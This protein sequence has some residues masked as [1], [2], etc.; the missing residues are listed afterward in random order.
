M[1]PTDRKSIIQ[2]IANEAAVWRRELHKHPQTMYEET[3]AASFISER[4]REWG[5]QHEC[6][7]AKTG[8][9]ATIEGQAAAGGRAIAFRADTDALDISEDS[10][11]PWKSIYPGKMHACGHDGHTATVLALARYLQQTRQFPGKVRLIFQPAEE[12][13]R[14]AARM[15]AEGLLEKYPFDEIYGFHNNPYSPAGEFSICPGFMLAATDFFELSLS[16]RGGHAAMPH[17]CDD[18]IVAGSQ[19]VSAVQSLVSRETDP[20][21]AAVISITNFHGGTGAANVMPE[22]VTLSGTVRTFKPETRVRIEERMAAL[23]GHVASMYRLQHR[24]AYNRITDAVFN[25]AANVVYSSDTVE[26]L[27]GKDALKPQQPIMGGEDFGS[28]LELRPGSFIFAGQGEA[29]RNSPHSQGLHT[30]RYEFNDA[31]IPKVVEYFADLAERR[32]LG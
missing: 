29:D 1:P 14:G 3:F 32:T 18:A 16:G 2:S 27:F 21:D 8:V 24:F 26:R 4:L 6:G 11:S 17:L 31:I 5:I 9:V 10:D 28:F 20:V 23:T 13:G 30:P 22:K 12:G 19:L 25:H 7:I 15:I